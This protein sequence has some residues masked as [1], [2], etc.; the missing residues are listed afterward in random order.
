[1]KKYIYEISPGMYKPVGQLVITNNNN[2]P[3]RLDCDLAY[4]FGIGCAINNSVTE[5][6]QLTSTT[7]FIHCDLIR[8]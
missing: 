7:Y 6:K 5:V 8:L 3:M 2:K 1:M 4:L